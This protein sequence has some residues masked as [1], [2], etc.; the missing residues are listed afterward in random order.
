MLWFVP[1]RVQY[2]A[3][4]EEP[5]ELVRGCDGVQVGLPAVVDVRVRLPDFGQHFNAQGEVFLPRKGQPLVHPGL[6]EVAIHRVA[7]QRIPTV[8]LHLFRTNKSMKSF[9][10]G[11]VEYVDHHIIHNALTST[12]LNIDFGP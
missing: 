8:N 11:A 12:I 7:L 9:L 10:C 5:H 4:G 6:P 2:S 3:V 1:L